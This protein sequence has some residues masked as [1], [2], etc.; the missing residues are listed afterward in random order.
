M[1]R[2]RIVVVMRMID[3]LTFHDDDDE[4]G[5]YITWIL[6][7]YNLIF[8]SHDVSVCAWFLSL[9]LFFLFVSCPKT[10]HLFF[11]SRLRS[12]VR[13]CSFVSLDS[14]NKHLFKYNRTQIK[15]EQSSVEK[16]GSEIE[17]E[18]IEFRE[19]RKS[20]LYITQTVI[21][22]SVCINVFICVDVRWYNVL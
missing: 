22:I 21:T 14:D 4:K 16:I 3:S 19:S 20:N 9:C 10:T 5:L 17:W 15:S 18:H 1:A 7:L 11:F 12:G 8:K 2:A 6:P 13:F